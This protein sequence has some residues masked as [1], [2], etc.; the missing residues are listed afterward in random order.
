MV[1]GEARDVVV[2]C[3]R[4]HGGE[5]P[6][7]APAAAQHL[8]P[9][10]RL[11]N[12]FHAA[13]QHR[14]GRCAQALGQADRHAVEVPG[15]LTRGY[16]TRFRGVEQPCAV[17]V[18]GQPARA[19]ERARFGEVGQGQSASVPGVL[20]GQ[21]AGA[22]VVR[23]AE[24]FHGTGQLFQR[25]RAV[26]GLHDGL[27]LDRTQHG[28]PAAFVLVG[29]RV[30]ADQV[31]VAALAV[32]H[33][34]GQVGL[35]AAGQEQPGLEAQVGGKTLLQR[36]HTGVVAKHVVAHLG[37]QARLAHGG[38]G[39]GDGVAAQVDERGHGACWPLG[40]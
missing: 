1:V 29:V 22:R 6:G 39:A 32:R 9:A 35:G 15:D 33:Q 24:G 4:G 2:E 25:Q 36:I 7:L 27:G 16:A 5:Q 37:A 17:Q 31:L 34:R 3:V 19:R 28:G 12:Q 30:H 13:H 18:V 21:Q 40:K 38:G 11:R 26:L 23:V 20:E 8:A 14:A 10:A